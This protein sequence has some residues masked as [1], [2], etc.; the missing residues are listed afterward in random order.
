MELE[1]QSLL[2][3]AGG[4]LYGT[5]PGGVWRVDPAAPASR[6]TIVDTG[7]DLIFDL[8]TDSEHLF[9]SASG[10]GDQ[11]VT[12]KRANLDGTAVTEIATNAQRGSLRQDATF[13]Y[14][15]DR[16]AAAATLV[17][18]QKSG[19]AATK[20]AEAGLTLVPEIA[21]DETHAYWLD[22]ATLKRVAKGGGDVADVLSDFSPTLLQN[23]GDS[24][25]FL[26]SEGSDTN[27]Y[28]INKSTS[29]R[30][31]VVQGANRFW[32]DGTLVYFTGYS[33]GKNALQS[34]RRFDRATSRTTILLSSLG[35]L[36]L[37]TLVYDAAYVYW[38][39]GRA[40]KKL[41]KPN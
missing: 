11:F 24:L 2:A 17:R 7:N 37:I 38:V 27:V 39:D 34:L 19:G 35:T 26:D 18:A 14:W 12:L 25:Y 15:F 23:D 6:K 31:E 40:A 1:T 33:Q 8:F 21:I 32:L 28:A 3:Q 13:L 29:E 41:P 22:G 4:Q 5:A 10:K 16:S 36:S 9:F 30:R 20:I